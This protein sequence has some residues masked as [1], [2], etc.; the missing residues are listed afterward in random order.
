MVLL[1][2][3]QPR[4]EVAFQIDVQHASALRNCVAEY[5]MPVEQCRAQVQLEHGLTAT[6]RPR[7][8]DEL[9][10]ADHSMDERDRG[11]LRLHIGAGEQTKFSRLFG[12][13]HC[14]DVSAVF[15]DAR[16]RFRQAG[17]RAFVLSVGRLVL[18]GG[19][20]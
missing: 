6:R 15:V 2:G 11:W 4:L 13:L 14:I 8:H 20:C 7:D 9:S 1:D 18:G 19:G 5:L 10:L 12:Q 17:L 16:C 3:F